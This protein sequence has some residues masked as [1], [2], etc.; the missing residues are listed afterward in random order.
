[1]KNLKYINPLFGVCLL[2]FLLGGCKE[3]VKGPLFD[4]SMPP[5]PVSNVIIENG[6]GSAVLRFTP[7][8]DNDLLYVKAEYSLSNGL[9]QE[10]RT[11]KFADT[12]LV[13]GFGDTEEHEVKIYAVD[14]GENISEPV[15]VKINPTTPDVFLVEES[16]EMIPE[17]GGVLFRWKNSNNAP[18]SF[19]VYA[20]DE[21]GEFSPVETVYSGVTTGSY[22]LRGFDP[23]ER[24][25]GIVVRD[26]WD[27]F[28]EVKKAT[29][30]P[31]FEQEL[32]K[33][34]FNKIILEGDSDM[35][36]WE[37][38]YEYAYDNNP[39]TFNHTWAGSG[40]P[41]QWS[42]DLGVT[43]RLS[44]VN[45]LQRQTFF[46]R[47]GNP[48]LMEIWGTNEDPESPD[49]SGWTKL[50]DCVATRPTLDGGTAD[51]DQLHFETGDEYGFSLD[52][53]PVRYVRFVVNETW[54][55]TGFIHFAEVTF[56]GQVQ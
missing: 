45:V 47:H 51:E 43:A 2:V 28:S 37:G 35:D 12:L 9:F 40:W 7:P 36:A 27:N 29:L 46:Y 30:T 8:S 26:R 22:T 5:G 17:F 33:D 52:D 42:L 34:K 1:M 4:D 50:C 21:D 24:E 32:D 13:E 38:L 14:G 44:R 25:F 31:L 3:D 39:N 19:I 15:T 54:G 49:F 53:P 11:S 48:R 56:Y 16:I 41:Q 55:N 18:L 10:V 20:E 6:P 23:E